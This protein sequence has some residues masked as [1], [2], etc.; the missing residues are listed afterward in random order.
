MRSVGEHRALDDSLRR[1]RDSF[2]QDVCRGWFLD[3][4][5]EQLQFVVPVGYRSGEGDEACPAHARIGFDRASN[6]Q[7]IE[8]VHVQVDDH[9]T[10]TKPA[11]LL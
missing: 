11:C 8:R 4:L 10:R 3:D 6:L 1:F 2:E 5:V 9:D 7:A